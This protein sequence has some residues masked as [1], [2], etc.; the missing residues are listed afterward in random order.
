MILLFL[1]FRLFQHKRDM[2]NIFLKYTVELDFYNKEYKNMFI[3]IFLIIVIVIL[4]LTV[5]NNY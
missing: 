1:I 3:K 2:I 5:I 4:I